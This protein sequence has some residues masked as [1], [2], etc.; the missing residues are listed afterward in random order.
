MKDLLRAMR[1]AT[2]RAQTQLTRNSSFLGLS[3]LQKKIID[4]KITIVIFQSIGDA[5]RLLRKQGGLQTLAGVQTNNMKLLTLIEK[6]GRVNMS[7]RTLDRSATDRSVQVAFKFNHFRN[8][9]KLVAAGSLVVTLDPLSAT[10][11]PS[12]EHSHRC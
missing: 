9:D 2:W 11:G 12:Q 8:L 6:I 10:W 7:K 1:L 5:L 4:P 3:R